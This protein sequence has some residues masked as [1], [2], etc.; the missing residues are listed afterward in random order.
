MSIEIGNKQ[1]LQ[2][3]EKSVNQGTYSRNRILYRKSLKINRNLRGGD[4]KGDCQCGS[5][6]LDCNCKECCNCAIPKPKF[7]K[8]KIKN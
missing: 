2:I 3:F 7:R 8:N 5:H 4:C 1:L 6:C